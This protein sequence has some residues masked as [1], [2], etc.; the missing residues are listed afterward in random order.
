MG[1]CDFHEQ[2]G[3]QTIIALRRVIMLI[4]QHPDNIADTMAKDEG[5]ICKLKL[6]LTDDGIEIKFAEYDDPT[7]FRL[8]EKGKNRLTMEFEQDYSFTKRPKRFRAKYDISQ[9]DFSGEYYEAYD[10]R[11]DGYGPYE[12]MVMA[13][14]GI[15]NVSQEHGGFTLE[16]EN[17]GYSY[18]MF[19]MAVSVDIDRENLTMKLIEPSGYI[20]GEFEIWWCDETGEYYFIDSSDT[21]WFKY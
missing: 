6:E 1:W 18:G 12:K 8:Y 14:Q 10:E 21:C 15:Y 5:L 20:A 3:W 16:D 2:R 9:Y 19:D 13:K 4:P 11:L 17:S 7:K